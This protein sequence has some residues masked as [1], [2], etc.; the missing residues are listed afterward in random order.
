MGF[1]ND[2]CFMSRSGFQNRIALPPQGVGHKFTQPWL[3]FD[4]KDSLVSTLGPLRGLLDSLLGRAG[5]Q[6]RE[7]DLKGGSLPERALDLDPTLMLSGNRIDCREPKPSSL[8]RF[9]G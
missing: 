8:A 2:Q 7:K 4:H 5:W 9:L 1:P 6:C 3:I